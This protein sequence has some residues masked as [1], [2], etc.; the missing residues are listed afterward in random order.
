MYKPR[1]VL[2]VPIDASAT[3]YHRVIQ[4]LY[5]L[6]E[7]GLD[8][9]FLGEQEQQLD[10]YKWA[11]VL[12]IQCLYA[13]DAYNFYFEQKKSG[14]HIIIDFDDDYINIPEDSPEQ[15]E[16]INSKTGEVCRFPTELRSLYVKMFIGLA[17]IVVVTTDTLKRLYSPF[18]K[19][20]VVI[21]NCISQDMKRDKP[22]LPNDKV[23]ILW[24]GS[25]SHKPD[26]VEA[27]EKGYLQQI[28][29]KYGDK[30]EFHFQGPLEFSELF[31]NLPVIAHS[32]ASF[33]DYLNVIQDINP[34]IA[35]APLK[36]NVFNHAKSNIKYLQMTLIEA[37]FVGQNL[38]PYIGI[39]SG[40]DGCLADS[41]NSWVKSL[42]KLIESS[43]LRAKVAANAMKYV[44]SHFMIEKQIS[45][46]RE[47]IYF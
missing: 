39:D 2:G 10:Q 35:I 32:V 24:S 30:V 6:M 21:P 38:N 46:W 31:P 47:L 37:A 9:Q 1:K 12:Y 11:D 45:K 20:I 19:K 40:H 22:K 8:I 42:S 28:N 13:P 14:K 29:E 25:A 3:S 41:T 34:D 36:N 16:I 23:R 4:P 26:L 18:A 44:E 17:D 33:S 7:E 15:T 27:N 43:D 5:Y